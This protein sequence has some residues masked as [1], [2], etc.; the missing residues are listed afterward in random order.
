MMKNLDLHGLEHDAADYSIEKFIT[1][2]FQDLPIK[3]ITGNSPFFIYKLQEVAERHQLSC[4]RENHVN[5]GCWVITK[6]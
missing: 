1:D 3:I 6:F 5:E 2:N 4:H